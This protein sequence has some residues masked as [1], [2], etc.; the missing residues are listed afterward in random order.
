MLW[1]IYVFRSQVSGVCERVY[2]H[3]RV[4]ATQLRAVFPS[5]PCCCVCAVVALICVIQWRHNGAGFACKMCDFHGQAKY[6]FDRH[7]D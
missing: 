6:E 1:V 7:D 5:W 3:V 4:H 2:A